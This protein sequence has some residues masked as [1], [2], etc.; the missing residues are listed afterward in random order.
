[1]PIGVPSASLHSSVR[2]SSLSR[3]VERQI[4]PTRGISTAG[5]GSPGQGTH[6]S[7]RPELQT[8]LNYSRR[9][10]AR[11]N[12]HLGRKPLPAIG[13]VLGRLYPRAVRYREMSGSDLEGCSG[14][15]RKEGRRAESIKQGRRADGKNWRILCE[16]KANKDVQR[17]CIVTTRSS[18]TNSRVKKSAPATPYRQSRYFHS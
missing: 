3:L 15:R 11:S 7:T 9:T 14:R 16:Q 12:R 1:M 13:T 8:T 2:Y 6:P 4:Q 17:T 10:P 18:T 5:L